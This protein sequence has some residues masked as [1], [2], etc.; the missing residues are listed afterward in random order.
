MSE[1]VLTSRSNERP[2]NFYPLDINYWAV[3]DG[4]N[5]IVR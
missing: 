4:K 2:I 3:G 5:A 1:E